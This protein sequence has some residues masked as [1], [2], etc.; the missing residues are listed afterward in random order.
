M[1]AEFILFDLIL[2]KSPKQRSEDDLDHVIK[3]LQGLDFLR[4]NKNIT[5]K[6]YRDLAMLMEYEE[7]QKDEPVYQIGETPEKFYVIL[8][9]SVNQ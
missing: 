4:Q 9:G 2:K 3:M 6:D 8:S 7:F 5:Y 1:V